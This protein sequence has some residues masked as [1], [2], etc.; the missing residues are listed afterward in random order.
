MYEVKMV[1]F[2]NC[3]PEELLLFHKNFQMTHNELL[4]WVEISVSTYVA[5]Y[6][7]VI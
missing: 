5:T 4:H 1:L 2:E 3:K 7:S 6:G